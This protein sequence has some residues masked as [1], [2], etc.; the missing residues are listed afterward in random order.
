[1]LQLAPNTIFI[2]ETTTVTNTP[3]ITYPI[4]P[5]NL[6]NLQTTFLDKQNLAI[7]NLTQILQQNHLTITQWEDAQHK[8]QEI[9]NSLTQ[10]IEQTCM[11][12]PTPPLP[13]RVK[14]QGGFLPRTLQKKWKQQLKIYHHIEKAI[15]SACQN[16]HA[17]LHN[18][19]NISNLQLI[20]TIN[21][22]PLPTNPVDIHTWVEQLATIGK[23]AKKE[24]HKII[25]KQTAINCKISITK[26]RTL[27]N[28]KPKIIHKKIFHPTTTS[29]LDCLQNQH[30]QVITK[31]DDIAR[32]IYIIQQKSSYRQ[33]PLCDDIIDH[34]NTCLCAVRK[35]PWHSQ[36]WI[37]FEKRGNHN[38]HIS[39][40]FTREV[41]DCC[42]KHLTK[43][44]TLGPDDI[45]NDIIKALPTSWQDLL[46]L[47]F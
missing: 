47:F 15:R 29:M 19:S 46:Y 21:I 32:E 22:P 12:P 27:L 16:P 13:N 25:T 14:S 38:I 7:E 17:L 3:R 6:Q 37:I 24:A 5:N 18:N 10:C 43:G 33:A 1:M 40:Q 36:Q 39:T 2:K 4:P 8:F 34:P 11:T 35:Y 42:I 23:N 45:P 44:K 9:T 30:S 26:Y 41:Y 20:Q 28:I 31:S